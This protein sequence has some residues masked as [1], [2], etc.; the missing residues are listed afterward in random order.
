MF[1]SRS[2]N[3]ADQRQ[4]KP[5]RETSTANVSQASK[6]QTAKKL[7]TM[8]VGTVKERL[9]LPRASPIGMDRA[10]LQATKPRRREPTRATAGL[11]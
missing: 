10:N 9:R 2:G 8:A 1:R 6:R 11:T 3:R 5:K 4:K 7:C